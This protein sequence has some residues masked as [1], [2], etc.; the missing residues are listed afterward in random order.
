MGDQREEKRNV[1]FDTKRLYETNEKLVESIKKSIASQQLI[2]E[3]DIVENTDENKYNVPAKVLVSK[4]RSLEAA[5]QYKNQKVC[6]LNFAS[7]SNP[8]GGVEKGASA[9]EEAICRCSTLHACISDKKVT[10][11]FHI[12]HKIML[13]SGELTSLYN[14]DCIYTPDVTVFKTDT[15]IPVLMPE[16]EWYQVDIISCAAPNLRN[17]PSNSMNPDAGDKPAMIGANELINL[18]IKRMKRIL[19]LAKQKEA[20]VVILGAFGCGAFQNSPDLV[21]EAMVRVIQEY[22]YAFR[23]IEFAVFCMPNDMKNYEIFNKKLSKL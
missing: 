15:V 2:L 19:D 23:T 12:R 4:K 18:H 7:A 3:E 5:K 21:A 6:V 17:T 10:V 8:G 20:E 16:P 9:Q 13:K 1:Y 22:R 14:D 11:N